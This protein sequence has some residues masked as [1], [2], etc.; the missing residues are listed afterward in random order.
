ME[1]DVAATRRTGGGVALSHD[2]HVKVVRFGHRRVA[3]ATRPQTRLRRGHVVVQ[4]TADGP[5]DSVVVRH[6]N[7]ELA[8]LVGARRVQEQQTMWVG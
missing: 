4:E 8:A 6:A 7:G 1:L 3:A 5:R 2:A